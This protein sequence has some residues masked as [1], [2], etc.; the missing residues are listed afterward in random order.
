MASISI[1]QAILA[2]IGAITTP[3]L[4][5]IAFF[6]RRLVNN[7]DKLVAE[8]SAIKDGLNSLT[9]AYGQSQISCKFRHDMVDSKLQDLEKK[10]KA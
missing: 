10:I 2:I 8:M 3:L 1:L 5:I 7:Q 6:L 4:G 9:S